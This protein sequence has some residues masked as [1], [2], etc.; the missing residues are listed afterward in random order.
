VLRRFSW[1]GRAS[2]GGDRYASPADGILISRRWDGSMLDLGA[3]SAFDSRRVEPP[4][5]PSFHFPFA[6]CASRLPRLA[7]FSSHGSL[8]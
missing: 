8:F 4:A 6:L 3:D 1:T 2:A 5:E 7:I